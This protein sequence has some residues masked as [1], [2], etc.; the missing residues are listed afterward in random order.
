M[1]ENK[2]ENQDEAASQLQR[3]KALQEELALLLKEEQGLLFEQAEAKR[4]FREDNGPFPAVSSISKMSVQE[5]DL[6]LQDNSSQ[7][8]F[9][10][11][12]V[13][14]PGFIVE[15]E[16]GERVVGANQPFFDYTGFT[17]EDI[18]SGKVSL[19][20][21]STP[22]ALQQERARVKDFDSALLSQ[23]FESMRISKDGW[24]RPVACSLRL[25]DRHPLK[26]MAFWLDLS[27]LR[28]LEDSLKERNS[29][30][31]AIVEEMPHIVF[32][33]N[34]D[35]LSR[36]FNQRFYELTGVKKED[37]D[38][39]LLK[40][41]IHPQDKALFERTWARVTAVSSSESSERK[42]KAQIA[43]DFRLKAQDGEYYWHSFRFMPLKSMNGLLAL[44][45]ENGMDKAVWQGFARD[46]ES[47]W[48]G[49][50]TDID[51]RKRVMDEVLESA[52]AFQSLAN[53]IP[54][55]VWTAAPDGKIE[56]LNERWYEFSG[57]SREHK[58]GLDFALFIHP[59]DRREYMNRW[60]S[61]VKT[62]D[63]FEVDFRL[64]E[65]VERSS[66]F[67]VE[68]D[69]VKFLARAVALRNYRGEIAQWIGTWTSI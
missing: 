52:Q 14:I 50:A 41:I 30:F 19:S 5:L 45:V 16:N 23:T 66:R 64:R 40:E 18:Y 48:I 32:V 29:I 47:L 10:L 1:R 37:D 9:I 51:R 7:M 8:Q 65:F 63:A 56:F 39:N 43:G 36:Q 55:I 62:G 35:G 61:S 69:Y 33:A 38:G 21:I 13:P 34:K 3:V 20:H 67:Q 68:Q 49:T 27:E 2:T 53:Q 54:Q 4:K 22:D 60:K 17:A 26:Y 59:D 11:Q 15:F 58:M 42:D 57:H 25:I 28:Y 6:L 44:T 12:H 24:L 46:E 31:S